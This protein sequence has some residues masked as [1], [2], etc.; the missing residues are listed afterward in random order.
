[1]AIE[2]NIVTQLEGVHNFQAVAGKVPI[3]RS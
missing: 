2:M 3:F 1:M